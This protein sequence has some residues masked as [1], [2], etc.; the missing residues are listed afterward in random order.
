MRLADWLNP[1]LELSRAE[2][3]IVLDYIH[4]VDALTDQLVC[5]TLDVEAALDL[6]NEVRQARKQLDEVWD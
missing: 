3:R 1:T 4:R 2:T 5:D 6:I